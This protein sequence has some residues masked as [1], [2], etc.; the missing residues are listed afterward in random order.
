MEFPQLTR[1]GFSDLFSSYC[2]PIA[3]FSDATAH[4][5]K[6]FSSELNSAEVLALEHCTEK[7]SNQL[8]EPT[9]K[10]SH[11][12]RIVIVIVIE[13]KTIFRLSPYGGHCQPLPRAR[14]YITQL[15]ERRHS[16]TMK[17][18]RSKRLIC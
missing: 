13:K 9:T 16:N 14:D 18:E 1:R 7:V 8:L 10:N 6:P 12:I 4:P 5:T 15:A 17:R 3:N 11:V 2:A